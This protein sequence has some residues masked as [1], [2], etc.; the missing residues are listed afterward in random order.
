MEIGLS[1]GSNLGDR[2]E[3]LRRAAQ[4]ILALPGVR[5]IAAAPVYQTEP[6][7]ARSEYR[8]LTYLNTVLIVEASDSPD[9]FSR[10]VHE[11]E[12]DLG[13]RRT[14]D[15]NAPRV[16]DI[17]LLYAGDTRRA[18]GVLDLPHPR[19]AER[20]FVV[21]PLADVRPTLRLPGCKRTVAEQLAHLPAMPGV[22]PF[23]DPWLI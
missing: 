23:A 4:R 9:D 7:G 11:I 2:L 18:D 10:R 6:V 3:N 5:M 15:R 8:H 17:D 20:R 22:E 19:W 16:I 12:T 14:A 21:Q 13:R 1:L